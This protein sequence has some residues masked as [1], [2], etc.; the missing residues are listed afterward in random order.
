MKKIVK[1]IVTLFNWFFIDS[2]EDHEK[3]HS[4]RK[5]KKIIRKKI[6]KKEKK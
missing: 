4:V 1:D 2:V 5:V 3:E 6:L